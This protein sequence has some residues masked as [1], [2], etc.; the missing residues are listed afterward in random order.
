[1]VPARAVKDVWEVVQKGKKVQRR[2]GCRRWLGFIGGETGDI[3]G[4]N[5]SEGCGVVS[6]EETWF[7]TAEILLG[8]VEGN[9]QLRN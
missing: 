5:R 9:K 3:R 1:M 7:T 4:M 2:V 8:E 6:S